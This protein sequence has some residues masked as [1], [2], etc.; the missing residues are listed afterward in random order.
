MV[1]KSLHRKI[2]VSIIYLAA[3]SLLFNSVNF[4]FVNETAAQG[5]VTP[6]KTKSNPGSVGGPIQDGQFAEDVNPLGPPPPPPKPYF[7]NEGLVETSNALALTTTPSASGANRGCYSLPGPGNVNPG[8]EINV[9]TEESQWVSVEPKD[10]PIVVEGQVSSAQIATNDLPMVHNSHDIDAYVM[11]DEPE[12]FSTASVHNDYFGSYRTIEVEWETKNFN[13]PTLWPFEGDRAWVLGRWIFDCGHVEVEDAGTIKQITIPGISKPLTYKESPEGIT[14]AFKTEIHPPQAVA[15]TR[16]EPYLF[17]GNDGP[18]EAVKTMIFIH[19]KGGYYNVPGGVGGNKGNYA[20]NIDLPPKP[21]ADAVVR[22]KVLLVTGGPQPVLTTIPNTPVQNTCKVDPVRTIPCTKVHV[23]IPFSSIPASQDNKYRAM[24]VAGW[25]E[26]GTLNSKAYRELQVTLDNIKIVKCVSCYHEIKDKFGRVTSEKPAPDCFNK[27]K[28]I[29]LAAVNGKYKA[30]SGYG[31]Q[32]GLLSSCDGQTVNINMKF[33]PTLVKEDGT[34]KIRITGYEQ[35]DIDKYLGCGDDAARWDH[36]GELGCTG[37][38][39]VSVLSQNKEL[40]TFEVTVG[41]ADNF[42]AGGSK[43]VPC[44]KADSNDQ[45]VL[46]FHV[47][48]LR[49]FPAH[50]IIAPTPVTPGAGGIAPPTTK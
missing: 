38:T 13:D 31:A 44:K 47:D 29:M 28:R 12:Y 36:A 22:T 40:C 41:A 50:H 34:L 6:P 1:S 17:S 3:L 49:K 39:A 14:G 23:F 45:T 37:T 43:S 18:S 21:S 9:L 25:D 20:F 10:L 30:L 27:D 2:A 8:A 15:Y 19:G 11:V 5:P 7:E 16:I 48:E 24:I 46:T 42:G 35:N 26:A 33:P 4:D 32:S